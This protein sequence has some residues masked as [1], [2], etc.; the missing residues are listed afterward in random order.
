MLVTKQQALAD[1]Q[2]MLGK[3]KVLTDEESLKFGEGYN[4]SYAKA[5]DVYANPL[6]I[7]ILNA[8]STT[9]ISKVLKYCNDN[10][11]YVIP[12]T[13]NS[14][15][16]GLLEVRNESTVILDGSMMNKMILIDEENMVAVCECGV[17]LEKLE[18]LVREKG[19]TTGHGPQSLPMA[20]MG[21]LVATRSTGQFSTYY[22]GIEDM[23]CG[24]EAVLPNGEVIRIRNVPRRSSGPDLRHLFIGG[25][26]AFGFI[27]EVT[28]KLFPF[29]PND[30]WMGG[31]KM[32]NM[33]DG[34]KAIHEIMIKGY[35]PS[36]VRL[37]DKADMDYNYKS[38]E[39]K[40]DE[41]YMFFVC[42]G[43]KEIAQITGE[44]IH[45][46]SLKHGGDF[47]GDEAVKHWMIHR[48]D[49]CKRYGNPKTAQEFRETKTMYAT[50]EIS[51]NWTDVVK[52]YDDVREN[53]IPKFPN[54]VMLGGHISHSY[55][56]G[57][58]IYFV[59]RLKLNSPETANDEHTALVHAI[60]EEVLKYP[61]G[62]CVH[63]HGMGKRRVPYARKEH[64]TSYPLM[65]AMKDMIDPRY[66][67]NPGALV[68]SRKY[69][70]L[71][72]N[73]RMD[74]VEG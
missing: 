26:G 22:G 48:N 53:V 58:N 60:C 44:K 42:E 65:V 63:H 6:P 19:L 61:S 17:P 50:T 52:I 34:L 13:G 68:E 14:S 71:Q 72:S 23:V 64:G 37:Y 39:M 30:M 43:P 62:G 33:H 38:V 35:K 74:I 24:L 18:N 31:Y 51:A 20:D 12:R 70:G 3:D 28:V 11:V 57:T 41:A 69:S 8:A 5:H 9:E 32:K 15:A 46:I 29:F 10:D 21:G 55:I 73:V 59:Y 56:N 66:I 36:V 16:E 4:R 67:M 40:D 49:L 7:C 1:F 54:L 27:T 45:E 47:I 2:N 25:E